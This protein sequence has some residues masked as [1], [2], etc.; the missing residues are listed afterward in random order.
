MEKATPTIMNIGTTFAGKVTRSLYMRIPTLISE[1]YEIKRHDSIVVR[2]IRH[3]DWELKEMPLDEQK[4][5][6][7]S[8]GFR[9]TF[10]IPK[11][12]RTKYNIDLG[13][14]LTV[15]LVGKVVV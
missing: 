12:L 9:N 6:V 4:T 7:V 11:E 14:S 5:F 10:T 8:V 2:I 1:K 3:L 13:D 15:E